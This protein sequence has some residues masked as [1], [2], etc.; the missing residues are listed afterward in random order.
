MRGDFVCVL[1]VGLYHREGLLP[2]LCDYI[3]SSI[4][5]NRPP[6][7]DLLAGG[8]LHLLFGRFGG[9]FFWTMRPRRW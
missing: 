5:L 8:R 7:R 2:A 6:L 4:L 9:G 1:F 3:F